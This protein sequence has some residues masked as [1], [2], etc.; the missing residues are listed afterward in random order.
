MDTN[1]RRPAPDEPTLDTGDWRAQLQPDS[2]Q[3][4][5]NKILETFKKHLPFSGQEGLQEVKKIALRFEENIYTSATSQSDYLRKI[6]LKIL[7]METPDTVAAI[8]TNNW[9]PAPGEPAMETGDWRARLQPNSRQRIVNKLVEIFR[10]HFPFPGQEGLQEIKEIALQFEEKIFTSATSL[11]DYLR[12][13]SLKIL[14]VEKKS[15]NTL[16]NSVPPTTFSN[17]KSPP[18]TGSVA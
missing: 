16:S 3:R 7:T 14:T 9:R 5:V 18:D 13:I 6:S 8:D 11:Y 4:I 1:N 10:K 15:K 17:G 2:R 12:K